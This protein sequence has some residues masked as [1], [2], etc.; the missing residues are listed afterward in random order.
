MHA[1]T[2]PHE[3]M[4]LHSDTL[5]WFCATQSLLKLMYDEQAANTNLVFGLTWLNI[6]LTVK[7]NF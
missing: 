6:K 1:E 2:S 3:D 4:P 7:N 5:A